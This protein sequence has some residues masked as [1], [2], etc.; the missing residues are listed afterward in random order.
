ME[1]QEFEAL[2]RFEGSQYFFRQVSQA[3]RVALEALLQTTVVFALR[4][5]ARGPLYWAK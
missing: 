3:L 1:L 2:R 4:L 5:L